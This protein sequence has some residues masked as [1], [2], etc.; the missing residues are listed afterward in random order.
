MN[1]KPRSS[2]SFGAAL[3][4]D[5][6]TRSSVGHREDRSAFDKKDCESRQCEHGVHVQLLAANRSNRPR[7]ACTSETV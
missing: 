6:E 5:G 1:S 4:T 7:A 3:V 2:A